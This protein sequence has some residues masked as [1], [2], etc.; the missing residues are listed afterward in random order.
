[1]PQRYSAFE[2]A[3][4]SALSRNPE[5]YSYAYDELD[6][7]YPTV[8]TRPITPAWIQ[9]GIDEDEL[10]RKSEEISIITIFYL[11]LANDCVGLHPHNFQKTNMA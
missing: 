9:E 2:R 8:A 1:M 7:K 4:Q 3:A 6:K 10:K 11:V 5:S